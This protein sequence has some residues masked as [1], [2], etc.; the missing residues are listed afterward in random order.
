MINFRWLVGTGLLA[1]L[2]YCRPSAIAGVTAVSPPSTPRSQ[3]TLSN[4]IGGQGYV[5]FY[6]HIPRTLRDGAGAVKLNQ[7][8]VR[9]PG[10][11]DCRLTCGPE[12]VNLIFEW[13]RRKYNRGYLVNLTRLP[14]PETYF[15]QFTWDDH[16]GRC[17]GYLNGTPLALPKTRYPAWHIRSRA[18][19]VVI[20]GGPVRVGD[21]V[22]KSGYVPAAQIIHLVPRA[23]RG[24][25]KALLGYFSPPAAMRYRRRLG[26]LLYNKPFTSRR[27]VNSWV[28]EGPGK[29]DFSHGSMRMQTRRP[30]TFN[31]P[32]HFVFWCRKTFPNRFV[33]KWQFEPV[34]ATG[35]AIIFFAAHA[36]DGESIFSPDLPPR[37]GIFSQYTRGAID[38]YHL[39]Y[40]ADLPLFQTGR[41]SSN[42]RKNNHF[43]LAAVGPVAVPPGAH[44]FQKLCLIK[45]GRHIQLLVNGLVRL[46]WMDN[47]PRRFGP[48]YQSGKIGFRQM[49]GTVG[50]YKNFKVWALHRK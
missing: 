28:M 15:L 22:A 20:G 45:D 47:N 27:D 10:L 39:S 31:G 18:R 30:G 9:F 48:A 43:Y 11:A 25:N 1:C 21:V 5:G 26:K 46:N 37:N 40:F 36:T 2:L 7:L 44:G 19:A 41:P 3:V 14:G 12:S 49:A 38:S 24:K 8:L 6:M 35:L 50:R 13:G 16:I 34:S 32:G 4:A 42:L 17:D 29:L 23:L 33:A